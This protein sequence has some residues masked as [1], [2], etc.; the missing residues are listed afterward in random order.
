MGGGARQIVRKLP[1]R[2]MTGSSVLRKAVM[3]GK[4]RVG[5]DR[6]CRW[7][8]LAAATVTAM[9]VRCIYTHFFVSVCNVGGAVVVSRSKEK[10][11]PREGAGTG[12]ARVP[13]LAA[14]LPH[15]RERD[16]HFPAP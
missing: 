10:H 8:P 15:A 6:G 11:N 5:G 4:A 14:L 1:L 2:G 7:R 13:S 12:G 9:K 16:C 3:A